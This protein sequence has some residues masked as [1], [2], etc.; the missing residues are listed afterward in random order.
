MAVNAFTPAASR[1]FTTVPPRDGL[2][3]GEQEE[4]RGLGGCPTL[5]TG[6]SMSILV[7]QPVVSKKGVVLFRLDQIDQNNIDSWQP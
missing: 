7:M 1:M 5:P 4:Y 6:G 3:L 2:D